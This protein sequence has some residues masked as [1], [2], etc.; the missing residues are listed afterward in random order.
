MDQELFS[1][2]L[3]CLERK[4]LAYIVRDLADRREDWRYYP[5]EAPD[6]AL[7]GELTQL[8]EILMKRGIELTAANEPDFLH[9]VEQIKD[10][11]PAEDWPGQRDQ[12]ERQN[13]LEDYE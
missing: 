8:V 4:T 3:D 5:E 7:R 12:Q 9:M 2:M 11:Q 1:L 10:E 6:E 13:W